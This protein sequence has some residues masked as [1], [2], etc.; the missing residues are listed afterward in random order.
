[1]RDEIF[2]RREL[3]KAE[4]LAL[5][6]PLKDVQ[7]LHSPVSI[8]GILMFKQATFST[9]S[10]AAPA[11]F[12]GPSISTSCVSSDGSLPKWHTLQA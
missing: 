5:A 10:L 2:A 11:R 12:R 8:N 9:S 3:R 6:T 4:Q 7:A 1:M